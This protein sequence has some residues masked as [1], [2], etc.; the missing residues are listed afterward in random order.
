M[1]TNKKYRSAVPAGTRQSPF[2]QTKQEGGFFQP[3]QE[4]RQIVQREVGEAEQPPPDRFERLHP[5]RNPRE[6]LNQ[7]NPPV[8][9]RLRIY[10]TQ[11]CPATA[12]AL[13]DYLRSGQISQ[14]HCDRMAEQ[15]SGFGYEVPRATRSFR[16]WGGEEG[17]WPFIRRRT[18]SHGR[19]VVVE[20]DRVQPQAG[21]TRYH[22]FVILNIRGQRF[23]VDGFLRQVTP[24][25]NAYLRDLGTRRYAVYAG[26]FTATPVR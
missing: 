5:D 1:K 22:Y 11:N 6:V 16:R 8:V 18:A 19:F 13:H 26:E 25:I 10:C 23:V 2:F 21:L 17:A 20:G 15:Q 4:V 9:E 12:A 24:G 14:A 3:R 7:I